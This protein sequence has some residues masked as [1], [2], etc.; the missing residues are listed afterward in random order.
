MDERVKPGA[1]GFGP[2]PDV[3]AELHRCDL[4]TIQ[5]HRGSH[6]RP[7]VRETDVLPLN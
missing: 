3:A 2:D 7:C 5:E 6:P 4:I 1:R